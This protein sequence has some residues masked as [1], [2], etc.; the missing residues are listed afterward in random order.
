[1]RATTVAALAAGRVSLPT[2]A[3]TGSS[4]MWRELAVSPV[5]VGEFL[6]LRGKFNRHRPPNVTIVSFRLS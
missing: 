2:W 5:F 4:A 1:M 6:T 3:R